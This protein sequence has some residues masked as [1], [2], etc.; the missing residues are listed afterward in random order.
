MPQRQK[1]TVLIPFPMA[2]GHWSS[3]GQELDLL[4]V[5]AQQLE[6]VGRI[7]LTAAIEVGAA[8]AAAPAKKTTAKEA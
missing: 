2:G 7:K 5:Q 1:Y 6:A 8:V 3:V 4:D